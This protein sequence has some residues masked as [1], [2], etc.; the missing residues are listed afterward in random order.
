MGKAYLE[1]EEVKHLEEVASC[2]RDRLLIRL[3]FYLG[4]RVSEVLAVKVED[5]DF[6]ER[7]VTILHLKSRLKLSC[8]SCGERLGRSH[9]YCPGC[10]TK[11]EK[12]LIQEQEHRRVRTLPVDDHT[13]GMLRDYI[14]RG[15]PVQRQGRT[16]IFGINR[17]RAW[18]II[19]EC[20]EK[21]GLPS[22]VNQETGKRRG[23]SPHRLRDAFAVHA[24]KVNDSGDGLRILQEHLG[25][26]VLIPQLNTERSP[27]KN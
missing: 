10:G 11:V 8:R 17:H 15:G 6:N 12:A 9:A 19:R 3:L 7:S 26:P 21:A 2:L 18:Q 13:L 5:V 20:A 27:V 4:C 24:M 23:V 1:A 14:R 22:L 16:L 25:Q